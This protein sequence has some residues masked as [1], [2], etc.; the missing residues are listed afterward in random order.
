MHDVHFSTP[1]LFFYI[2]VLYGSLIIS[3]FVNDSIDN[4]VAGEGLATSNGEKWKRHRKMLTQAFHFDILK[5]YIP[6]YSEVC[7]KLLVC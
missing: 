3:L 5:Q 6:V 7:K 1:F 4:F 2:T